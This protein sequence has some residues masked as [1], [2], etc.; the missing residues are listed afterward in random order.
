MSAVRSLTGQKFSR[1]MVVRLSH[2]DGRAFWLCTCSCGQPATVRSDHLVSGRVRSCGCI[3][4]EA[5]ISRNIKRT[6]HGKTRTPE[7]AAWQALRDRCLNPRNR[8]FPSYGGRGISVCDR[9][10]DSFESFFA[11]MGERPSAKHSIDRID[12]NA[13]YAPANCRWA[14]HSEQ[15]RNRRPFKKRKPRIDNQLEQAEAA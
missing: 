11:D 1:L 7:F 15:M 9:W 14:T 10:Q 8:S 5:T 3:A 12:N 4:S 13:G 2:V 6:S